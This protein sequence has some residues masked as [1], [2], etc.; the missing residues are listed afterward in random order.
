[1]TQ[2]PEQSENVFTGV[3]ILTCT[4]PVIGL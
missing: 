4:I 3:F 2:K 1:L